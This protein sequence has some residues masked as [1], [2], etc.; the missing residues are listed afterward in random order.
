MEF[1]GS[2]VS[3]LSKDKPSRLQ[4]VEKI[5]KVMKD[6]IILRDKVIDGNTLFAQRSEDI[7]RTIAI[8]L[9]RIDSV[10]LE[11]GLTKE[12]LLKDLIVEDNS[13]AGV[14]PP[15]T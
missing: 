9:H 3:S 7:R 6:H 11:K 12:L 1:L 5:Q 15:A 8:S 2:A 10:L 14:L 13:T 4:R